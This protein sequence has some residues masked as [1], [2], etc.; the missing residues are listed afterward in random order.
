MTDN[1]GSLVTPVQEWPQVGRRDDVKPGDR[2]VTSLEVDLAERGKVE[3]F[4][5]VV[6]GRSDGPVFHLM[7]GQHGVELNGVAAVEAFANVLDPGQLSGTVIAVPVANPVSTSRGEQYPDIRGDADSNMNRI[8]PGDPEGTFIER[9]A[10]A[11]WENGLSSCDW[12]LDIHSWNRGTAPA[13]LLSAESDELIAFGKATGLLFLNI[14]EPLPAEGYTQY[15]P[16]VARRQGR[17][18]GCCVELSGQYLIYPDQVERGVNVLTN[19]MKHAGML[20][21]TPVLPERQINVVGRESVELNSPADALIR[22]CVAAGD[23]VKAGEP[24][25]RLWRSDTGKPEWLVSPV[26]GGLHDFGALDQMKAEK[27]YD[28]AMSSAVRAGECVATVYPF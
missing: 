23:E 5:Y 9:L 27:L 14:T 12:C 8:W 16:T 1:G 15:G 19:L 21:G 24:V 22:Q 28:R 20:P 2:G 7:A 25:A 17:A 6:K 26:D 11:I 18:V 10:H 4:L 13:A 3:V